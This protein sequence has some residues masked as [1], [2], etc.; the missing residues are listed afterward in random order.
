MPQIWHATTTTRATAWKHATATGCVD[1]TDLACNDNNACNGV[2]TCDLQPD[3]LM[4]QIWHATT[5]T[6]AT[7]WKQG[8]LQ[9]DASMHDLDATTTIISLRLALRRALTGACN[10]AEHATPVQPETCNARAATVVTAWKDA[11]LRIGCVEG[12]ALVCDDGN[13]CAAGEFCNEDPTR[14]PM[15]QGTALVC[16]DGEFCNGV[17]TCDDATGCVDG[18]ASLCSR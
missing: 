14:R 12:T 7:A 5:T 3:A 2:E 1:A 17:E 4:P 6:R 8:T 11:T 10:C 16:D 18:T 9:P 15:R 13:A